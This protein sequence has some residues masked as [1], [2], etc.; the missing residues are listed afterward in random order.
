MTHG[1]LRTEYFTKDFLKSN[2]GEEHKRAFG[3][4]E[5]ALAKSEGYPD[6][7]TGRYSN[8]LPYE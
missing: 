2:F 8:K 7:G 6:C 5:D 3:E 1:R 4:D